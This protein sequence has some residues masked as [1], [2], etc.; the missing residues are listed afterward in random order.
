M[1]KIMEQL[2]KEARG[3]TNTTAHFIKLAENYISEENVAAAR[4]C[5]LLLCE[6]CDNY[7]ESI[8]WNGLSEQWQHYRYLVADMVPPSVTIISTKP[9]SPAECTMRITDILSL[10][11]DEILSTLSEHLGELSGDGEAL[12]ALNKW[13]RT[14]YYV[15]ELCMEINSGGFDRYLYYRGTHFEKAYAALKDIAAL[16][17]LP[18]LDDIR[19]KFPKKRIP[20]NVEALQN[21]MD[22]LEEKGIDFDS[23]DERFYSVG[24]KE[25]LKC[26][27]SYVKENTQH[28]R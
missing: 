7:E 22:I 18:I 27:L 23:E 10:P 26:L 1:E 9:L 17:T 20:K 24:E 5:L 6:K 21:V 13:E 14:I 3:I 25:L 12:N 15:D 19:N 2:R 11:N 8:E 4:A 16:R 28:L